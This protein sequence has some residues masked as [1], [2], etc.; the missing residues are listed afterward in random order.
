MLSLETIGYYSDKIG[1]Q[2]YPL[3]QLSSIYPLQGNFISFVGNVAS[4]SLVTNVVASFRRHIKFPSEGTALPNEIMGVS[5][6]DQW[7]FWQQGYPGIMVTDTA[8][9][10]Y[11]YYHTSDDTPD[12]VNYDRLARVVVGLEGAIADLSGLSQPE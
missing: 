3:P 9:F 5:W 6:S 8:P 2:R 4:G 7:S 11:P 10:R 12:K 1:S